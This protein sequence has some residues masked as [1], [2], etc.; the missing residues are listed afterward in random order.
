[1]SIHLD[2]DDFRHDHPGSG[3][4]AGGLA[5][6]REQAGLPATE[7]E[8][9]RVK[10]V[11]TKL[12][13]HDVVRKVVSYM[14]TGEYGLYLRGR[15]I[16]TIDELTGEWKVMTPGRLRTWLPMQCGIMPVEG[17]EKKRNDKTDVVEWIPL[18][19][20][21]QLLQA[22]SILESDDLRDRL[23]VVEH[24]HKVKLPVFRKAL[25]AGINLLTG[26]P[27]DRRK[28]FR[29]MELLKQGYDKESK[30]FTLR[31]SLDYDEDWDEE[32]SRLHLVKILQYFPW[33]ENRSMAVQF[34]AMLTL[35]A[36]R[37]FGGRSPMF[38]W[39]ANL[40]GS[41]KS[42]LA[43][44]CVHAVHGSAARAGFSYEDKNE[45]RKELDA[46]AQA[47]GPYVFFDDLQRGKVRNEHL[48]RWLTAPDW[49]CRVM[50]TKELFHGPLYAATLMTGNEL[51]LNDDL[52]RRTL[53]ID[54]FSRTTARERVLPDD[55]LMLDE[56]FF[57]DDAARSQVLSALWGWC[58]G[59]T[60]WGGR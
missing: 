24:I 1:M 45:V 11:K 6:L 51:K 40:P 28:S 52:E 7:D 42:R 41:G 29:K 58:S 39:N 14:A 4:L 36:A 22:S 59:G 10:C 13:I 60:V 15:E 35:F 54:L 25:D 46:C 12:P 3:E 34:S 37:L 30:T 50:G 38:M 55:V 53:V 47:F 19:G 57:A 18:Y 20:E 2:D 48:H 56:D 21:L 27:D 8:A 17:F 32:R 49:S 5:T 44:L 26:E 43:Q 16:G 9:L 23:P 33:A 31:G